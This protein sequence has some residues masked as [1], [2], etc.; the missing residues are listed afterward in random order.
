M[1]KERAETAAWSPQDGL[2]E[3]QQPDFIIEARLEH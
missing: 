2:Q 1:G 3:L